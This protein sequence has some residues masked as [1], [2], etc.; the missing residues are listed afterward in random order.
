MVNSSGDKETATYQA[1]H[2]PTSLENPVQHSLNQNSPYVG[3]LGI[4]E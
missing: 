3:N 1:A 2:P 4:D